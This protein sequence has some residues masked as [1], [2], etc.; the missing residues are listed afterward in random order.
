MAAPAGSS[1]GDALSTSSLAAAALTALTAAPAAAGGTN[2]T[3]PKNKGSGGGGGI[4]VD[5]VS[6]HTARGVVFNNLVR[7]ESVAISASKRKTEGKRREKEGEE[8]ED[9]RD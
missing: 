6:P 3:H 7:K 9:G 4:C 2:G 1:S 5:L 8:R